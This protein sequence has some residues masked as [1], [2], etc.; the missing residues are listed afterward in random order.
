LRVEPARLWVIDPLSGT[1]DTIERD[2]FVAEWDPT[3]L[4]IEPPSRG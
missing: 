2:E 4:W 1:R 3:I